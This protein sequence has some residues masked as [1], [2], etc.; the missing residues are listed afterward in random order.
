MKSHKLSIEMN[1]PEQQAECAWGIKQ[2]STSFLFPFICAN[3]MTEESW[4][5]FEY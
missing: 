3:D 1:W 5:V 4:L 2:V